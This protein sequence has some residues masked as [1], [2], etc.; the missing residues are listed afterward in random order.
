MKLIDR[1]NLAEK[2]TRTFPGAAYYSDEQF[3]REL[4]RIWFKKWLCAGR[5]E[6]VPKVGDYIVRQIGDESLLF[7]RGQDG[8]VHGFYNTCRHRG[9]RMCLSASGHLRGGTVTCPY[10]SWKYS[11]DD[12]HLLSAPNFPD[13]LEG[14]DRTQFP[15]MSFKTKVWQGFIWC[16]LDTE[17]SAEDEIS[18][19]PAELGYYEKYHLAELKPGKVL[20]YEV[21][22]NWKLIMENSVECYHCT[23]IHPQLSRA[24]P[25][26]NAWWWNDEAPSESDFLD[27]G[28]M[29]LAENFERASLT[30]IATR[31]QFAEIT[32]DDARAVYYFSV[33]PHTL[34]GL[35][36]DYVFCFSLWPVSA[37]KT[38]VLAYW[39]ADPDLL[40]QDGI[41]DDAFEFW[42]ITNKQD[43]TAIELAQQG[44]KSRAFAGGGVIGLDD[45][46]VG[47]FVEYIKK[48]LSE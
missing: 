1:N 24:T 6:E 47:K 23:T 30:G 38:K 12:G 41:L 37:Q 2:A 13:N 29:T 22:A 11:M 48:S 42:D 31:P 35:A 8:D 28:G 4:E 16:S 18:Q 9:S 7:V 36:A 5:L 46:L 44:V 33:L 20:T 10:H 43:W 26:D 19:L 39:L 40:N 14:F 25:P 45:W 32:D 17:E 3:Q 15:L 21:N 34:F 27:V